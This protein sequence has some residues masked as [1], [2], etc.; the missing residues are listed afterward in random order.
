MKKYLLLAALVLNASAAGAQ[1][2]APIPAPATVPAPAQIQPAPVQD[3]PAQNAASAM[4]SPADP[5]TAPAAA[6]AA[7]APSND[8]MTYRNPYAGEQNNLTN[9]NRTPAEIQAWT[10]KAIASALSFGP[11][12]FTQKLTDAKKLFVTKGWTEYAEYVKQAQLME[13]VRNQGMTLSTILNGDAAIVASEAVAGA[14]RWLLRAP[15]M[16]TFMKKDAATGQLKPVGTGRFTLT[17][18]IGRVPKEQG[19]EGIA[20]ESWKIESAEAR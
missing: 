10:Q 13:R 6:A 3:M 12:D 16:M 20:I 7:P 9:P 2:P 17:L 14:Y 8:W 5:L 1:S 19:D 4:P 18:Q 11:D 15:V